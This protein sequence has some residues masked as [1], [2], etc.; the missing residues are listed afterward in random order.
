MCDL[1]DSKPKQRERFLLV[2]LLQWAEFMDL[3]KDVPDSALAERIKDMA[4]NKCCTLIYTVS[5][6]K[7][8]SVCFK[9]F[10]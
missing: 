9:R 1:D 8:T 10:F 7:R 5:D 6:L 4:P 2:L 3:G